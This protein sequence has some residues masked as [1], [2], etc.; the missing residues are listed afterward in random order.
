MNPDGSEGANRLNADEL[1]L[2]LLQQR[3]DELTRDLTE[4]R[5]AT[6]SVQAHALAREGELRGR[7]CTLQIDLVK[8]VQQRVEMH[9]ALRRQFGEQVQLLRALRALHD[10]STTVDCCGACVGALESF[11]KAQKEAGEV[12]A[13]LE[14]PFA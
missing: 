13:L 3:V 2:S 4:S 12:L 14:V 1:M 10:A 8:M 11:V 7:M 9:N 5:K 6:E